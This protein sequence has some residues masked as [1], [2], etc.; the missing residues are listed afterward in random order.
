MKKLFLIFIMSCALLSAS[1]FAAT[2]GSFYLSGPVTLNGTQLAEGHYVAQWDGNGRDV[3][4]KILL[5]GKAVATV[6]A[7]L[8][9]LS[10]KGESDATVWDKN[11]DGTRSVSEIDFAGKKYA[12]AFRSDMAATD[13]GATT[14]A[15]K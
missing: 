15:S 7:R 10:G 12:L 2:K 3:Q 13:S 14:A 8:I 11:A 1:A 5:D 6:P 9:E 4:V